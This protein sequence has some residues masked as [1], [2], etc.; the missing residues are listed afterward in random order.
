VQ[1]SLFANLSALTLSPSLTGG[2]FSWPKIPAG[3]DLTIGLR[4]AEN[5][6]GTVTEVPKVLVGLKVSLGRADARPTSG[7]YKLHLGADPASEGVNLTAAIAWDASAAQIQ[8]ALEALTGFGAVVVTAEGGTFRISIGDGATEIEAVAVENTLRPVAFVEW[9]AVEMND[10]FVHELRLTQTPVAQT[11][12]FAAVAADAPSVTQVQ[13]G[14]ENDDIAWNEI[15]RLYV[16]PNFRGSFQVQRGYRKTVP[17]AT[18]LVAEE[19]ADALQ[20]LAEEDSEF[21]V[22]EAQDAVLI[23]FKGEMGG[24]DQAL[25]SVAVLEQP[26]GDPTFTLRTSTAEMWSALSGAN[27]LTGELALQLEVKLIF[28]DDEED[29]ADKVYIFKQAL[30]IVTPV[31][32]AARN[33]ASEIDWNQPRGQR[34]VL[35]F[36]PGQVLIGNRDYQVTVGDGVATSFEINHNLEAETVQVMVKESASGRLVVHG[37]EF[38]AEMTNDNVLTLTPQAATLAGGVLGSGAWTVL[39]VSAGQAQY[40]AHEHAIGEIT[41][42]RAE[43]DALGAA[44]TALEDLVPTGAL[45]SREVVSGTPVAQWVLPPVLEVYPSRAVLT[46]GDGETLVDVAAAEL[47]RDGGLVGAVHDAAASDVTSLPGSPDVG[48]VYRYTG[49]PDLILTGGLGR[50]SVTI[51]TNEHVAWDGRVWFRVVKVDAAKNSWYPEDFDRELFVVAVS[52]KQLIAKRVAELSIGFEVALRSKRE[53]DAAG[54]TG[55]ARNTQAQW[56]LVIEHGAFTSESS[57]STTDA[58]LKAI[59]W[60]DTPILSH[61]LIVTRNAGTHSFGCRVNRSAG[62]VLSADA[63]YYGASEAGGSIP[64][65]ADFALRARLV[66]F[67]IIDGLADPRGLVLLRGLNVSLTEGDEKVGKLIIR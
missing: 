60:N 50:R 39:V 16:P 5:L 31:D 43:L 25:L 56:V 1:A 14:G 59:T 23:E 7:S 65:A 47:P 54:F 55:D 61:R 38:E 40:E 30:T 41:G 44:V 66:R 27:A 18:P 46:L 62:G 15:Q 3:A 45:T 49:T 2:A 32:V 12:D 53:R 13:A 28:E 20:A 52:S 67:D 8:A 48:S 17:L 22:T 9:N 33:V 51:K 42:L 57:P 4:F 63:I 21:V 6:A 58:N 24:T 19:V 34:A 37:V 10:A 29:E 36:T 26:E 35:P 64:A 11:V